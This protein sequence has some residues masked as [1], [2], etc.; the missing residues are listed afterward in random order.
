MESRIRS[1]SRRSR[2]SVRGLAAFRK[3]ELIDCTPGMSTHLEIT[4]RPP[5]ITHTV[6]LARLRAWLFSP[7]GR[8]PKEVCHKEDL[9][10]LVPWLSN[11]SGISQRSP[12]DR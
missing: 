6:P 1:R 4:V 11:D 8:G 5:T 7:G 9:K 2:F 10:A 12:K 3:A